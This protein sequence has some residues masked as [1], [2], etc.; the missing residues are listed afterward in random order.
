MSDISDY[1][2]NGHDTSMPA[3]TYR[4]IVNVTL[5]LPIEAYSI[6]EAERDIYYMVYNLDF[7]KENV[8]DCEV[9]EWTE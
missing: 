9:I 8:V 2:E 1:I 6:D 4:A 5:D 7:I 3:H